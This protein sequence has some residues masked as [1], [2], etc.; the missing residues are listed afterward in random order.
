[1]AF[2]LLFFAPRY[3][4]AAEVSLLMPMETVFGTALVWF[5]IGEEP[6]NRTIIGGVVIIVVLSINSVI[7]IRQ[8][9]PN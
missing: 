6:S 7:G 9:S 2:S 1:L 4:S 3:I 8:N 5:Y